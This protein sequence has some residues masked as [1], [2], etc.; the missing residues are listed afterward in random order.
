MTS[1]FGSYLYHEEV[2]LQILRLLYKGEGAYIDLLL[3]RRNSSLKRL[4]ARF[5]FNTYE[6]LSRQLRQAPGD[7]RI[8]RLTL[9]YETSLKESL[10]DM[11]MGIAF[12]DAADF[13]G[14]SKSV[15]LQV[16]T[17][18]HK[19]VLELDEHGTEASAV[20][21][22]AVTYLSVIAVSRSSGPKPKPF[23]FVADRPFLVVIGER[24][25]G[26]ILFMGAV[27]DPG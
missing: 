5:D 12:T 15:P 19:A 24:S 17:A 6:R 16:D 9:S 22:S 8:P 18:R 3:P 2:G 10:S 23:S 21:A 4:L 13:S 11:G 1:D 20:K 14:I 27:M 25:T 26:T 7:I